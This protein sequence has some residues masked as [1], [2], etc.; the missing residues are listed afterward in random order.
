MAWESLYEL[1]DRYWV[2]I[3]LLG[4]AIIIFGGRWIRDKLLQR[5][6]EKMFK[7]T[8]PPAPE[9]QSQPQI[10]K[11]SIEKL[12]KDFQDWF[13]EKDKAV[14]EPKKDIVQDISKT[15][16][17]LEAEDVNLGSKMATDVRELKHKISE[18]KMMKNQI[19]M[20][21]RQLAVLFDKYTEREQQLAMMLSGIEKIAPKDEDD[22]IANEDIET[23]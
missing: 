5:K 23:S 12:E 18:V 1:W 2:F 4:A 13:K 3:I 19:Q 16:R 10:K 17:E 6:A 20:Y 9:P 14:I 11:S 21:G 22:F 8:L 7:P 15:I